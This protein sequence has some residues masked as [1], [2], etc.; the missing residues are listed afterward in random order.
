MKYL[1]IPS[2]KLTFAVPPKCGSSALYE[3]LE[4]EFGVVRTE[5]A[6]IMMLS[7]ALVPKGYPTI[8]V[9]RNPIDRFRSL[10]RNKCRDHG[11]IGKT[12]EHNAIF[13]MTPYELLTYMYSHNN[14]HW[15][16]Q[17]ELLEGLPNLV[18]VP[19]DEFSEFW[20]EN[21][22]CQY[23]LV[24]AHT[25]KGHVPMDADLISEVVE[26]YHADYDLLNEVFG[27]E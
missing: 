26:F 3:A 24:K 27:N 17:N 12:G 5:C 25:T 23:E 6:E 2:W 10:W 20:R 21:V 9:L 13:D 16:P 15:T 14:D 11:R 7:K 8:A 22:P 4:A 18:Y 1:H 19:L